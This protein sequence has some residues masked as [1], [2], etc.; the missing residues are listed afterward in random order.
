MKNENLFL[1]LIRVIML[2]VVVF[3][4]SAFF[5]HR[6]AYIGYVLVFLGFLCVGFLKFFRTSTISLGPDIV[7]GIIDNGILAVMAIFG[8]QF[9][10]VVGAIV[11]GVVG[12]AI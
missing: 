3:A 4:V 2:C 12:N 7:F 8:G 5:I 1:A 9:A 10:G 11:G 6:G